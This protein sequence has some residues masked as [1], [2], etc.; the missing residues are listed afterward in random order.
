MP[1]KCEGLWDNLQADG[2]LS[3]LMLRTNRLMVY[4]WPH[5]FVVNN[6]EPSCS[7]HDVSVEKGKEKERKEL[8]YKH[9]VFGQLLQNHWQNA[10]L[11]CGSC[12]TNSCSDCTNSHFSWWIG[13]YCASP[14]LGCFSL[15]R[16]VIRMRVYLSAFLY[17]VYGVRVSDNVNINI[18][19]V[20]KCISMITTQQN[21]PRNVFFSES[22]GRSWRFTIIT[23]F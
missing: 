23:S 22:E 10:R 14:S 15:A 4:R 3:M 21:F 18:K 5:M 16:K 13:Q 11:A 7:E 12:G 19:F 8:C 2:K 1:V 9:R 20:V 17:Y 6:C